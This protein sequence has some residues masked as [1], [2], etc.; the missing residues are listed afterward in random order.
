[1][2]K[3][4]LIGVT[5]LLTVGFA[6]AQQRVEVQ[7]AAKQN[8]SVARL[9][10]IPT[11]TMSQSLTGT[12]SFSYGGDKLKSSAIEVPGEW[13]MQGFT[14]KPGTWA[15]YTRQFNIAKSWRGKRVKLRFSAVYSEAEIYINGQKQGYHLG[16]FTPFELDITNAVKIGAS[17]SIKVLV[18][19]E[20]V[21]DS[22]ASAS[23][24]A[25]HPLGGITRDVTLYAVPEV[26][27]AYYQTTTLFDKG[28]TNAELMTEVI[29]AN[30]SAATID[31]IKVQLDLLEK[32]S[33]RVVTSK[34]FVVDG[35]VAAGSSVQKMLSMDVKAPKKWDTEHPNL[36]LL[37]MQVSYKNGKA[38]SYEKR[39]GFRQVDI[40]GNQVLVNG[41]P[42]K[43]RGVCR[44]EVMPL[45]G[46]S[47]N[48]NQWE[49]DVKIF[50]DGNVNYIRTSHYPPDEKLAYA[51]D[52]LGM[53]LEVEAPFCWA[54]GTP[55]SA[56]N[57]VAAL[58]SQTL[59]M[60]TT[61][62]SHPSVIIWSIGNES[63]KYKEYFSETAK[64]V[65]ILDP[66]RPRNFSQYG[67]DG[68]NNELEIGNHHYPGSGGPDTY[69]NSK[70]PIVFDEYCH[71]NAYNRRELYTDPSLRDAWGIGFA[72]M[73]EN[74]Y[75]SQ[76]VLGG[77]LWAGIDDTFFL[78]EGKTVGYGTWGPVDGWR[79]PK[80]EYWHMKKGYSPIRIT[81]LDQVE[82]DGTKEFRLSIENRLLFSDLDECRFLWRKGDQKGALSV[83]GRPREVAKALLSV[84][85]ASKEPLILDVYDPRGVL[86]DTY[87]FAVDPSVSMVNANAA[88]NSLRYEEKD[89]VLAVRCDDLEFKVSTLKGQIESISK[90]GTILL[91][92][93]ALLMVQRTTGEGYG[94]Q[95]TG[96][97]HAWEPLNSTCTGRLIQ[98]A[99]IQKGN[100]EFV[101]TIFDEYNEAYGSTEYKLKHDG[102]LKV[103]YRYILKID[104]NPRQWG[105]VFSVPSS[106]S[107]LKWSRVGLWSYYPGDH[108]GRLEGSAAAHN[109]QQL[110][111][112]AGP[113]VKPDCVWSEDRNELGTNDFR[114]TKYSI[115]RAALS[116]G[117]LQ[118][119]IIGNGSV[120][121]RAWTEPAQNR[122]LVA[123]FSNHGSEGF[124][125]SHAEKFDRP[126]RMGDTVADSVLIAF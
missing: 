28:F 67:P 114:S 62:G 124:F 78:P 19:S 54:E 118:L 44:H 7:R 58:E 29:L 99:T 107:T 83:S 32:E 41:N 46:R 89:G 64:L 49:Q 16:G 65:K 82:K 102:S 108:I 81:L 75:K 70:R 96:A 63:T 17:N 111:G 39:V 59:D 18:R 8:I 123:G 5:A 40:V 35:A 27:L 30:E 86:C 116:D 126:L 48:G 90:N 1:M 53:F 112:P 105:V 72:R 120:D 50:R 73:W 43:L 69:R 22:L 34:T 55:V 56:D 14:V 26:N 93:D 98:R 119:Q 42:I 97:N 77:A 25:V 38:I 24:Y 4:L 33:K 45:R 110:S 122:L 94:T 23:K 109:R 91:N 85:S 31:G 20:S 21:V 103:S 12:W 74:M 6:G 100:S 9:T 11:G 87:S 57:R 115:K 88:F 15:E 66:T 101:L 61:F 3:Y 84:N 71:L 51:C 52:S 125:R 117:N 80:P 37:K 92:G 68:D 79:R 95:M 106:F 47:L 76:G 60:V 2:R 121:V 13:V 10:T 113:S 36:Y 104:V